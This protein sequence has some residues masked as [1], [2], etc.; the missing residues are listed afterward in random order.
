MSKHFKHI[1]AESAPL[2]FIYLNSFNKR[3]KSCV[4]LKAADFD[5]RAN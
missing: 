2:L 3:Y 5:K 1:F 4:L